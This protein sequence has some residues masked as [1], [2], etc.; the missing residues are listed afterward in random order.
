MEPLPDLQTLSDEELVRLISDLNAEE[1]QISY[2]RRLLQGC[3]D[4]LRAEAAA[5]ETGGTVSTDQ[6]RDVLKQKIRG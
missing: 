4:I 5:R 3:L 6:L 2:H 1:K